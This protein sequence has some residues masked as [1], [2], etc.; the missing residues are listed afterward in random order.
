MDS[1]SYSWGD[2]ESLLEGLSALHAR[3]A[4]PKEIGR[5]GDPLAAKICF[6]QYWGPG[7]L[8][9]TEANL[10]GPEP[11]VIF[12]ILFF[13]VDDDDTSGL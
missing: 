1:G 12:R 7:V 11:K 8:S 9:R 13:L 2:G 6:G 4:L 10:D 3:V 5:L